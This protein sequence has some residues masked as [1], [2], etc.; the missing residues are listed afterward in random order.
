MR[1]R[2]LWAVT[3]YFNP[4]H[5]ERRYRNYRIF[6]DHLRVPLVTVELSCGEDSFQL[7]EKD[8]DL[9]IQRRCPDVLWQKERLLNIGLAAL[10][11][12]CDCVAWLDCDVVFEEDDWARNVCSLLDEFP[13]VQP[14]TRVYELASTETLVGIRG[15]GTEGI[16]ILRA[17][18]GLLSKDMR[19]DFRVNSGLAWA[20]RRDVLN[21]SSLYD[22]CI[23]GS[24]NR[25]IVCAQLGEFEEAIK[26]LRMNKPWAEHYLRWARHHY[27][28]IRGGLGAVEGRILH[29][30]HG[31]LR[32]R[33]YRDR[34]VALSEFGFNPQY[35]VALDDQRCWRGNSPKMA[36]HRYVE[37]YFASRKEDG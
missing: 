33:R 1:V 10:P 6:R 30:W 26:Y 25:A 21:Q 9:L 36:M 11:D 22:A 29:L 32:N 13:V 27:R 19:G 15:D 28:Q 7:H 5:Y 17:P 24:G 35:D 4:A 20:A 3:C 34:H 12:H 23:L 31:D 37:A 18:P 2:E 8:A 14:Y 16:S